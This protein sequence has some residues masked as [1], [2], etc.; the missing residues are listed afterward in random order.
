MGLSPLTH[1]PPAARP[2]PTTKGGPPVASAKRSR[3]TAPEQLVY[4]AGVTGVTGGRTM[5]AEVFPTPGLALPGQVGTLLATQS[6]NVI[7]ALG[8]ARRGTAIRERE[9]CG[10]G[11]ALTAPSCLAS[12]R[13]AL[14]RCGVGEAFPEF[15]YVTPVDKGGWFVG[16]KHLPVY[17]RRFPCFGPHR[18]LL[19]PARQANTPWACRERLSA[20]ARP[21][22][23]P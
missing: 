13:L 15:I 8:H 12:V 20:A 4:L 6:G 10:V 19:A 22:P 9:F 17:L 14:A 5:A 2:S 18:G 1:T 11:C 7:P 21:R 16:N 3:V 23:P